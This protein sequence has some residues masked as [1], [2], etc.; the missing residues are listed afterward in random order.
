MEKEE[1]GD[2]IR[3]KDQLCIHWSL[4]L[5]ML[6][7]SVGCG[8]S[9]QTGPEPVS[10]DGFPRVKLYNIKKKKKLTSYCRLISYTEGKKSIYFS[11]F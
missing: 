1:A 8:N 3:C 5:V 9:C 6:S 7:G 2:G 10:G 4:Y 11:S